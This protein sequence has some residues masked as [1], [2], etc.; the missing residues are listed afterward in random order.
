[1]NIRIL[2]LSLLIL[3]CTATVKHDAEQWIV[4]V[5]V[6][7]YGDPAIEVEDCIQDGE[8]LI[9]HVKDAIADFKAHHYL[10]GII[11]LGKALFMIKPEIKECENIKIVIEDFE[12]IIKEFLNPI[13][14]I[15][16]L[17]EEVRWHGYDIYGNCTGQVTSLEHEYW[18]LSGMHTGFI[19]DQVFLEDKSQT[20][21]IEN[22]VKS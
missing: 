1:M 8:I 10:K 16:D 15:E 7:T 13:E 18:Q 4:G 3:S 9:K 11:A 22:L 6:G 19:I 2:F 21:A 5:L 17:V 20:K 12:E 14:L